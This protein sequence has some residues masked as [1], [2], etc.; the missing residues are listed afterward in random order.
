MRIY[1]YRFTASA[2]A[3]TRSHK[4]MWQDNYIRYHSD[5]TSHSLEIFFST[6]ARITLDLC[7]VFKPATKK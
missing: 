2:Q 3:D 7:R 1:S 4:V 5:T 6:R